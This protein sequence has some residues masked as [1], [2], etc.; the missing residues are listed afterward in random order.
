MVTRSASDTGSDVNS[1]HAND[2]RMGWSRSA[3]SRLYVVLGRRRQAVEAG[4]RVRG[5]VRAR[6]EDIDQIAVAE[7]QGQRVRGLV[8][9]DVGGVARGTGDDHGPRRPSRVGS[10]QPV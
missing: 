5:G 10:A 7:G 9:E 8:V 2:V 1:R 4:R 6:R 3:M